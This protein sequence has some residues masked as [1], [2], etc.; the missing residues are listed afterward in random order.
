MDN[1]N[2]VSKPDIKHWLFQIAPPLSML[3][4]LFGTDSGTSLV[5]LAGLF[6]VPVFISLI[7]ILAKVFRFKKRKYFM[8]RP[9]LTIAFFLLI[10]AISQWTYKLALD[11]ATGIA[12]IIHEECNKKK[13]CPE[14]PEGWKINGSSRS[15]NDLGFW[16]RYHASYRYKPDSFKIHIYQGPDIGDDISGGVDRPFNVSRYIENSEK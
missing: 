14:K 11:D 9:A 2:E 10:L 15:R 1:E 5:F 16:F 13:L 7:S 3:G 12:R 6:L 4:I 8:I